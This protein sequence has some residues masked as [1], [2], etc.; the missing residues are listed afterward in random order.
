MEKECMLFFNNPSDFSVFYNSLNIS[1]SWKILSGTLNSRGNSLID[2]YYFKKL[3][4]I[5]NSNN[6]FRRSVSMAEIVSFLDTYHLVNRLLFIIQQKIPAI[7]Y[8]KIRMYFEYKIRFSKNRRIDLIL[9]Y[10]NKILLCEFR[11]SAKFPNLS[12][13]WQKKEIELIIYKELMNNYLNLN[14]RIYLYAF[15][16]LPEYDGNH[17]LD[18]N[19]KYNKDNLNYFSDYIIEYLID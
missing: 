3:K 19:I 6:L 11:L 13:E 4:Y 10:N 18:K 2:K 14:K 7:M 9:E 12:Q 5:F 1:S 16:G 8:N 15:I 17:T